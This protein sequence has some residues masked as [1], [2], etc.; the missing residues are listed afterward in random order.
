[1]NFTEALDTFV[2]HINRICEEY[3]ALHY[4]KLPAPKH[5]AKVSK[6]YAKVI[7]LNAEGE[8]SSVFCFVRVE[9]GAVLKAAG[10][11]TPAKH[12]RGTIYTDDPAEYGVTTC[13]ARYL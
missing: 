3:Y 12:A 6:K 4:P 8:D 13:G 7:T 11:S 1:M 2:D 10:W 5:R 9:D